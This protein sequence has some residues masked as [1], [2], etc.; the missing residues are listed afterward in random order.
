MEYLSELET[1]QTKT[2]TDNILTASTNI[3]SRNLFNKSMII[4]FNCDY[5][6]YASLQ[7]WYPTKSISLFF[8]LIIIYFRGI[9]P[10]S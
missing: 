1:Q 8:C 5:R 6:I 10:S 2:K 4:V 7:V 3:P 9:K